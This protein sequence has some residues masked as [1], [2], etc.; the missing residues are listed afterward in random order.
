M[1]IKLFLIT[2][3]V[4]AVSF[5]AMGISIFV[6]K[7]GKFPSFEIGKNKEMRKLGITCAK[8]DEIK[9]HNRHK[10]EKPCNCS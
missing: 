1:L 10:K 6:K 4:I 3:V 9:C 7:N 8:H 5:L 2:G